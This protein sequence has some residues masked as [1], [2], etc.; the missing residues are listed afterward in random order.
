MN[1]PTHSLGVVLSLLIAPLALAQE[2]A[3]PSPPQEAVDACAGR[4]TGAS[5]NFQLDGHAVSGTCRAPPGGTV[6]A[7]APAHAFRGPPP[8]ALQACQGQQEGASCQFTGPGGEQI[9]GL[10]RA[11]PGGEAPACAPRNRPHPPAPGRGGS[12]G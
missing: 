5:C 3:P 1:R 4:E 2:S 9:A 7:C 8:E 11:G 10:C 6:S 12:G